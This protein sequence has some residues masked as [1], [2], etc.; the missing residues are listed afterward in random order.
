MDLSEIY[1]ILNGV[2]GF[3][4]KVVYRKWEE[5]QVPEMPFAVYYFRENGAFYADGKVYYAAKNI[6]VDLYTKDKEP[7]T[8]ALIEAALTNA[9]LAFLKSED[10]LPEEKCNCISYEL[11]V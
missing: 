3:A 8:E 5:G 9:G 1:T 11:G 2:T 10:Y 4:G 6:T 7:G